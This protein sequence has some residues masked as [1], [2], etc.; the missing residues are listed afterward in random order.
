MS[1]EGRLEDLGLPDIFQ[2]LSLSK[3]S[4]I[5]TLIRKEGTARLVFSQGQII[6]AS[7]DSLPRL[8]YTLVKKQLITNE[9][10]EYALRVQK[11][12]GSAKPIGTILT[13]MGALGKET[14][15]QE[16]KTHVIEVIKELLGW[17]SGSFHFELGS[18]LDDE[19]ILNVG[20][21]TEFL[22]LEASRLR[23]EEARKKKE[24]PP[25]EAPPKQESAPPEESPI[26]AAAK[27]AASEGGAVRKD[28]ILLTSMIAELSGPNTSSEI[29][30]MVLRFASEIM[31]RAIILMVRKDDIAGLGQFGLVVTEG[32][33]DEYVR[34]IRI[35]INEESVF[36]DV[37]DKKM[38]YRGALTQSK[39]HQA[40]VDKVGKEW[41]SEVFLVP[42]ICEGRVIALLYGDDLP[43]R[44]GIPDT[45]G[46][47]SFIKVAGFAF[48]KALLERRLQEFKG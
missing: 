28:L 35:P 25:P 38:T 18:P 22:L 9:N 6:F 48:G 37:I 1:L 32:S 46:L 27:A 13:E 40:F 33:A 14:L 12:R 34:S 41:P 10:L 30:L 29:T 45:E 8:G 16:I 19:I 4:G 47:E 2:I 36:K 5:L 20:I 17:E 31:S 21:N 23:D 15:E 42:L 11:G 43:N 39:L 7:E 26:Q 24:A 3:R 44:K